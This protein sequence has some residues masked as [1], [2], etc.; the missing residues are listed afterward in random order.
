MNLHSSSKLHDVSLLKLV[1]AYDGNVET[2]RTS[3]TCN[4]SEGK[5]M[6]LRETRAKVEFC[7]LF[8]L[9][10]SGYEEAKATKNREEWKNVSTTT[11]IRAKQVDVFFLRK[12][13]GVM[14][15]LISIPIL[16]IVVTLSFFFRLFVWNSSSEQERNE[17][18]RWKT[19]C[20]WREQR[21]VVAE[22]YWT[23]K[24]HEKRKNRKHKNNN[25]IIDIDFVE[26]S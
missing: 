12:V 23:T 2:S 22:S 6:S 4:N 1:Y 9:I 17:G 21:Q 7:V 5:K 24:K 26:K 8:E 14:E 25:K 11:L 19:F 15:K 16:Q 13:R 20:M 10:F 3:F 18:K